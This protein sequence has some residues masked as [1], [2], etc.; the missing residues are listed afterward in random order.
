MRVCVRLACSQIP[1]HLNRQEA[2]A[3]VEANLRH[4]LEGMVK[5]LF[6]AVECRWV[7]AYFPF[8]DPSLELEVCRDGG[9]LCVRH[10]HQC[11]ACACSCMAPLAV[12]CCA[13]LCC[14]PSRWPVPTTCVVVYLY[15]RGGAVYAVR[16]CVLVPMWCVC[17]WMLCV[18]MLCVLVCVGGGGGVLLSSTDI[19]FGEG[20][21]FMKGW[22]VV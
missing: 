13:V 2:V 4:T 12:L 6:G 11:C 18:W 19:F 10:V 17:V 9:P 16:V 22:H 14:T 1:A 5:V 3:F 20:V 21:D 7:P 15:P 8:T